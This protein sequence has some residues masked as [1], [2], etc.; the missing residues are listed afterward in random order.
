MSALKLEPGPKYVIQNLC[1]TTSETTAV[2]DKNMV[3]NSNVKDFVMSPKFK[4]NFDT[5]LKNKLQYKTF[6]GWI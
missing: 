1:Q 4:H 3:K 5:F 6:I 2:S